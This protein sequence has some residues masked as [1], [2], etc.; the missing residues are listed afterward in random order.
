MT[1][2]PIGTAPRD[3]TVSRYRGR[4]DGPDVTPLSRETTIRLA[5][6]WGGISVE[7]ASRHFDEAVSDGR[8]VEVPEPPKEGA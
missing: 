1:W 3:G 6:V 2:L 7:L 8:L 5:V 4:Y